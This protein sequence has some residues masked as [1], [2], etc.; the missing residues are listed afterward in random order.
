MIWLVTAEGLT[1]PV[2]W[3]VTVEGLTTPVI[4]MAIRQLR[5]KYTRQRQL[6]E[7]TVKCVSSWDVII[8]LDSLQFG[9]KPPPEVD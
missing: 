2:I 1:T 7:R 9:S 8:K 5:S 4:W 6:R 3:L